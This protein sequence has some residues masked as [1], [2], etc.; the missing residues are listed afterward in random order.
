MK[1]ERRKKCVEEGAAVLFL[2]KCAAF[3][4]RVGISDEFVASAG[5]GRAGTGAG[6]L[7]II[8]LTNGGGSNSSPCALRRYRVLAA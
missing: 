3:A 2:L 8:L 6:K 5:V 4:S 1:V 7:I